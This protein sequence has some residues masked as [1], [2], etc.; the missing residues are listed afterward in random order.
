MF[1]S[2]LLSSIPG[3]GGIACQF[4]SGACSF[5]SWGTPG[6]SPHESVS[7]QT[8]FPIASITKPFT[9]HLLLEL[10]HEHGIP[11]ET[12]LHA[13]LAGFVL[14]DPVATREMTLEDALCHFSGL[15]P[16]TWAWVYSDVDRHTFIRE[17][18]PYLS[19]A[20]PHRAAH[21]YSNILYAVLGQVIETLSGSPWEEELAR[22]IL[23]PLAMRDTG[24]LTESWSTTVP[25]PARPH[26]E[27]GEPLPPFFAKT[28][29]L[30][31]PASEMISTAADLACWGQHLLHLPPDCDRW[32]VRNPIPGPRP[33]PGMGSVG[34]AL[35]WRVEHTAGRLRI[36]HSGQC[37]GYSTLL[38]LYPEQGRGGVYLCN[39]SGALP[40]LHAMDLSLHTSL[41]PDFPRPP[42]PAARQP[43]LRPAPVGCVPEGHYQHPGYGT[44]RIR[45]R[46]GTTCLAYTS[47]TAV[48]IL[49]HPVKGLCF[50]PP[51]YSTLIALTAG[52]HTLEL[53]LEASLAPIRF[54]R[55]VTHHASAPEKD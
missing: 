18:L 34:Y 27:H 7:P 53:A 52:R 46:G 15:P 3:S 40:S 1:P 35:G 51:G 26:S 16:H 54:T 32:R 2:S 21:R 50:R 37:S 42:A 6:T 38:V 48:P 36:W 44:L 45:E 8:P 5:H 23:M 19:A 25:I 17:R 20:A 4:T 14:A 31:A 10:L 12:P 24:C 30:I 41:R 28:R 29:H 47:A 39:A 33:F 55:T 22:R 49:Q 13:L 11:L 9:A 43:S